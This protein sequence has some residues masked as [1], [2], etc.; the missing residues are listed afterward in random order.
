MF[1]WLTQPIFSTVRASNKCF[2]EGRLL[3]VNVWLH[4]QFSLYMINYDNVTNNTI[5]VYFYHYV[6]TTHVK[7]ASILNY[8]R[9]LKFNN[10]NLNTISFLFMKQDQMILTCNSAVASQMLSRFFCLFRKIL[11]LFS[12]PFCWLQAY[13]WRLLHKR[14]VRT[15]LDIYFL[16]EGERNAFHFYNVNC[17]YLNFDNF[18]E[19]KLDWLQTV[20]YIKEWISKHWAR[21][22]FINN[23]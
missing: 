18:F 16:T 14:I 9:F 1:L 8:L 15:K 20:S 23:I 7:M 6:Y 10:N 21:T 19:G 4:T 17:M 13:C 5:A 11:R 12:F 2:Q 22:S 3:I